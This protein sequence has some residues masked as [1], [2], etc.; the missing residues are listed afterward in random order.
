MNANTVARRSLSKG[1]AQARRLLA[2]SQ[3]PAQFILNTTIEDLDAKPVQRC[4]AEIGFVCGSVVILPCDVFYLVE[5]PKFAHRFYVVTMRNNQ[6]QCSSREAA[7]AAMCI[8]QVED[9][10]QSRRLAKAC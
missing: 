10:R 4:R 7:C 8:A 5:S 1:A 2:A 3:G 6:W 9:A